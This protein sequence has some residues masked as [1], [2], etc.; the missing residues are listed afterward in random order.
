MG[1][2]GSVIN[3]A[4]INE[5]NKE[6][7]RS[8]YWLLDIE[9]PVGVYFPGNDLV[10]IRTSAFTTGISDNPTIM[11]KQIR[12]FTVIQAGKPENISGSMSLTITDRIDQT[13]AYWIDQWK[14]ACGDRDSLSGLPLD[15]YI[16]RVIT[17]TYYNI[18]EVAVRQIKFLN[19]VIENSDLPED[20]SNTPEIE[21]DIS[22]QIRYAHFQ[23]VFDNLPLVK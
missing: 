23:R 17:A 16:S 21:D 6:F 8:D 12:T 15:Q 4:K 19:C 11:D 13:I 20:G 3:Y 2:L 7:R 5:A 18:N 10:Q 9:P 1:R 22:L 14:L